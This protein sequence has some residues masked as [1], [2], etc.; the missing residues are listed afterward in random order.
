ME[1]PLHVLC[2]IRY[3][4]LDQ[5][6]A[7]LG[8]SHGEIKQFCKTWKPSVSVFCCH[9]RFQTHPCNHILWHYENYSN[10]F[11][12][13]G[14]DYSGFPRLYYLSPWLKW[15]P[16]N[17]GDNSCTKKRET[18]P[19]TAGEG[20]RFQR[21]PLQLSL[22]FA[23]EFCSYSSAFKQDGA[24]VAGTL[25]ARDKWAWLWRMKAPFLQELFQ[26]KITPVTFTDCLRSNEKLIQGALSS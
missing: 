26:P 6:S 9:Q 10:A 8:L 3:L 24:N 17:G 20:R 12:K 7:S 14:S 21:H 23:M 2:S 19:Y 18:F 1:P 4:G 25:K 16:Y 22:T 5:N 13:S 11:K 15:V